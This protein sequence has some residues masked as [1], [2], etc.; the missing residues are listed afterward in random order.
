M[1]PGLG[2]SAGVFPIL[3]VNRRR[4]RKDT[5]IRRAGLDVWRG[6]RGGEEV[7]IRISFGARNLID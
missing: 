6:E 2:A 1:V 3:A 7:P 5:E 4:R